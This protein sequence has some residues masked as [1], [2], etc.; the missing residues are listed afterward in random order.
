[1]KDFSNM[2]ALLCPD[3]IEVLDF[4]MKWLC[5][6]LEM[7]RKIFGSMPEWPWENFTMSVR[8][9]FLR[10]WSAGQWNRSYGTAK[11]NDQITM[12]KFECLQECAGRQ[13]K[14]VQTWTSRVSRTQQFSFKW[15]YSEF[16]SKFL[17]RSLTLNKLNK[18]FFVKKYRKTFPLSYHKALFDDWINAHLL[19]KEQLDF[20]KLIFQ[21]FVKNWKSVFENKIFSR[22]RTVFQKFSFV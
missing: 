14:S 17:P 10:N 22:Q 19:E 15:L 20:S 21:H 18:H 13:Q 3:L 4:D 12:Q 5:K 9:L 1:M 6:V 16:F 7:R 2:K 11:I 8:R